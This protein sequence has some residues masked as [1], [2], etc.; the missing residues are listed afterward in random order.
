L[1]GACVVGILVQDL[2]HELELAAGTEECVAT[3][4]QE[5][6]YWWYMRKDLPEL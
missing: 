1:N 4:C 6:S 3:G 2:V 5:G